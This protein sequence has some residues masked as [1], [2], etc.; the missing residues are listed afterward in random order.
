M[1][2]PRTFVTSSARP[3]Q[4]SIRADV[5]PHGHG[6]SSMIVRSPVAKRTIGYVWLLTVATI[7]PIVPLGTGSPDCGSHTCTIAS[8]TRCIPDFSGHS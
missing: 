3:R 4:P 2:I 1:N 5:R 6:A 7:S 8:S